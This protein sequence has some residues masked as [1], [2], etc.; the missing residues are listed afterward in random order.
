M[1]K[2]DLAE[3]QQSQARMQIIGFTQPT[4]SG[5]WQR[6]MLQHVTVTLAHT[7]PMHLAAARNPS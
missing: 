3:L 1:R 2:P 5:F 4:A 6:Q 7:P